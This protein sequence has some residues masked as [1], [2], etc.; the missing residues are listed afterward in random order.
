MNKEV[1]IN[2]VKYP[3]RATMGALVRYKQLTGKEVSE[4]D[5]TKPATD[6]L[7]TYYYCCLASACNAD[8]VDFP[9]D[10]MRFCDTLTPETVS[11][12]AE[13]LREDGKEKK[14]VGKI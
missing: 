13:M 9:F 7:C 3:I 11:R 6:E 8:G 2:G 5:T 14:R 10:L 4:M 1:E 12:M